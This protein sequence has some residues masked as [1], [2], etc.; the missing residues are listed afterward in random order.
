MIYYISKT[1][2]SS[3]RNYATTEREML[4][5]VFAFEKFRPYLMC[6]KAIVYTDHASLK[7]FN[8]K[9]DAKSRLVRWV[10]LFQ[11]FDYEVR[12]KSGKENL[13]AD[14]LSRLPLECYHGD[15]GPIDDSL[16]EETL[17]AA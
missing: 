17:Y 14:H 8:S 9:R 4:V 12:D 11:E 2:D 10:L 1:L 5:I 13:V 16:R 3:Q 7:Y 6:F 15:S